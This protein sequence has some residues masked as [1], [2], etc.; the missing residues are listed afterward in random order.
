MRKVSY[1]SFY[2]KKGVCI[3]GKGVRMSR[4][5]RAPREVL[6]THSEV[7]ATLKISSGKLWRLVQSGH[8]VGVFP[9]GYENKRGAHKRYTMTSV[10]AYVKSL[11]D[12]GENYIE[13]PRK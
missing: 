10:S 3:D 6:L 2:S 9:P 7:L 11:E 5:P 12:Y 13:T 1:I 8:I 4:Y